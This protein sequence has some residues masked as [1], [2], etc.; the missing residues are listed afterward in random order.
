M[1]CAGDGRGAAARAPPSTTALVNSS[2][3]SGIPSARAAISRTISAGKP[4][5]PG[6]HLTRN[7]ASR[8]LIGCKSIFAAC[9]SPSH[10]GANSG[11]LVTTSRIG[12][13]LMRLT[14]SS[15][16]SREVGSI[17]CASSTSTRSVRSAASC[18]KFS[19]RASN[20]RARLRLASRSVSG[21]A[22]PTGR[23]I[24]SASM[25]TAALT[26]SLRSTKE[27][28]SASSVTPDSPSGLEAATRRKCSSRGCSMLFWCCGEQ[29]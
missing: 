13:R 1:N 11:R 4:S 25:A 16:S 27:D 7:S 8:G 19:M 9:G 21:G 6:T 20:R 26:R 5:A 10:A 28:L 17:Q 24:K 15:T 14:N 29:S 23:A 22:T 18:R 3:K 12:H 2:M